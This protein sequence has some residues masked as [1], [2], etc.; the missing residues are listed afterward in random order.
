MA[1]EEALE[2]ERY[3]AGELSDGELEAFLAR[4]KRDPGALRELGEALM[5]ESLLQECLRGS[6]A[7][8]PPVEENRRT[9]P[10]CDVRPAIGGRQERAATGRRWM[11]VLALAAAILL[12]AWLIEP[13]AIMP[14]GGKENGKHVRI[15]GHKG[16]GFFVNGREHAA[17]A[18][19][20]GDRLEAPRGCW[21]KLRYADGTTFIIEGHARLQLGAAGPGK[22]V[23]LERGAVEAEVARQPKEAPLVFRTPRAEVTVVGT[24]LRVGTNGGAT[25]VRVDEG[26]VRVAQPRAAGVVLGAGQRAAVIDKIKTAVAAREPRPELDFEDP[27]GRAWSKGVTAGSTLR[28]DFVKGRKSSTALRMRYRVKFIGAGPGKQW[29]WLA[30]KEWFGKRD[31]SAYGGIAFWVR[32]TG[33]GERI[34]VDLGHGQGSNMVRYTFNFYDTSS[35]W[36]RIEARWCDFGPKLGQDRA[37]GRGLDVSRN[38]CVGIVIGAGS[39]TLLFDDFELVP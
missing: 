19:H 22:R 37:R 9:A 6:A 5:E 13:G 33:N 26:K 31:W 14:S 7:G 24:R 20:P 39:G 28:Y 12:L 25:W 10:A 35:E 17:E 4:V 30:V 16:A 32:G 23:G 2:R 21:L 27:A 34:G 15:A 29:V 18:L 38:E 8:R 11:V 3:L 1:S 36:R